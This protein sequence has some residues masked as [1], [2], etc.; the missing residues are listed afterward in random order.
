M[1]NTLTREQRRRRSRLFQQAAFI[2]ILVF[3]LVFPSVV[4]AV[5]G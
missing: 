3:C 1:R 4:E 2:L 5:I